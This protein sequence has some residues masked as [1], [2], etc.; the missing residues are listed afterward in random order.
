MV[1]KEYQFSRSCAS[2]ARELKSKEDSLR[3]K[4]KAVG[5]REAAVADRERR[6][7]GAWW[8]CFVRWFILVVAPGGEVRIIQ[9]AG[10][11]LKYS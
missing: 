11:K 9:A 2:K 3:A 8:S 4:E 6:M 5:D 1:V 7:A 10:C